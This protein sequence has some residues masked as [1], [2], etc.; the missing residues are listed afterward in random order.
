MYNIC[1]SAHV[2]GLMLPGRVAPKRSSPHEAYHPHAEVGG[3]PFKIESTNIHFAA[4]N[5]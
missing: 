2:M 1:A 4:A 3:W 5:Y